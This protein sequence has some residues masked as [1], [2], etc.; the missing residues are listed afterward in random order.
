MSKTSNYRI[1]V[2]PELHQEFLDACK[3]NDRP[4]AQIVREF[5]KGYVLKHR[6]GLQAELFISE[7]SERYN[8][9]RK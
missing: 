8:S 9:G 7:E 4:A 6:Q 2:E 1:R 5:M 3:T